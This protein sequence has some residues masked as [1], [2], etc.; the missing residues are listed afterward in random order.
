MQKQKI[1]KLKDDGKW[2]LILLAPNIIGFLMFMLIPV[3]MTFVLSF[4]RYDIITAPEFTGL[5]NYI[6]L[7]KDPIIRQTTKNTVLY[8]LMVVPIGMCLSLLLAVLLDQKIGLKRFFR[9][10]YFIPAITSMVVVAI[11][12]QWIYNPEFGILN[13]VLSFFGIEGKRW[14]L[15]A[16]TALPALA[17]VGI[18]KNA[19]YNM[20]IF[21]SGLQGISNTYYE[22]A[23]LDGATRWQ[24]F[25]AITLPLLM[26]TTFFVFVTSVI[27][28][29]QVFDQVMLMTNGGPGR[30]TSVL[31]HYLYQNA[32][33]YFKMGYACAIAVL[34]FAIIM[35]LTVIN[36]RMEKKMRDIF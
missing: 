13:W 36:M 24:Q 4:T 19:G 30:A 9:A 26:P 21:L 8:S 28:S 1:S 27:S 10:A 12:W 16:K 32:F 29:F 5:E 6:E 2:A 34:L 17:V 3:I 14:L 25:R 33:K 23:M 15:D 35:A 22:A 20:I 18:W 11:V 7:F 31:A